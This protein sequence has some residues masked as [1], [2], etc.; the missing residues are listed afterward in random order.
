MSTGRLRSLLRVVID[1]GA[2]AVAV[3]FA[4][5][6][7]PASLLFSPT[8]TSGGDMGSCL[9]DDTS[10][11]TAQEAGTP[12]AG[13]IWTFYMSAG[14]GCGPGTHGEGFPPVGPPSLRDD[15]PGNCGGP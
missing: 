7:F 2:V 15:N 4:A 14:N 1:V 5:S 11:P 8:I 12:A 9:V 13:D 10:S 3:G 6:Y